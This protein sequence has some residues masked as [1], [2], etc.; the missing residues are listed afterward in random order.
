MRSH[1]TLRR[2]LALGR[3]DREKLIRLRTRHTREHANARRIFQRD[4][5][6][7]QLDHW[8]RAQNAS[9]QVGTMRN[10]TNESAKWPPSHC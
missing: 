1:A 2:A 7:D 8:G 6:L 10:A 5:I 3:Q 4:E 9:E